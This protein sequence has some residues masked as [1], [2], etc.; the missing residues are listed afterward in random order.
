MEYI[1]IWILAGSV[2]AAIGLLFQRYTKETATNKDDKVG[3]IVG[4][5]ANFVLFVI[6]VIRGKK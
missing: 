2:V 6:N 5:W 3:S 4:Y 1:P